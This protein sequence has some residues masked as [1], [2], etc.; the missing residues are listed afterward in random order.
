M[1]DTEAIAV[2]QPR[3]PRRPS[4]GMRALEPTPGAETRPEARAASPGAED[5]IEA[6]KEVAKPGAP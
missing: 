5:P 1:V 6:E 3:K 2:G 4:V